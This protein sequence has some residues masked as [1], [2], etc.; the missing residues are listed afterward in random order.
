A[1]AK[2][3]MQL[4]PQTAKEYGVKNIFDPKEN[5]FAGTKHFKDLL[6]RFN[7]NIPLSLAAYNAG[8]NRVIKAKGIPNIEETKN[9]VKNVINN[10]QKIKDLK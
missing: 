3:L 8:I 10:Y 9:Y 1:G 6:N 5:I 2:G 7:D 4:M